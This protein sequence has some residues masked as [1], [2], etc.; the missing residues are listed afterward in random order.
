MEN[1]ERIWNLLRLR[2]SMYSVSSRESDR[3]FRESY[4]IIITLTRL[5]RLKDMETQEIREL[6]EY[7]DK[8]AELLE[9]GGADDVNIVIGRLQGIASGLKM[10]LPTN[11]PLPS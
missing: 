9:K 10:R 7:L 3:I 5:N 6:A 8:T 4:N 11:H 2:T 1:T